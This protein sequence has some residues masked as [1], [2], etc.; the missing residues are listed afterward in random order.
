MRIEVGSKW[1]CTDEDLEQ[2][3]K[4]GK[5]LS[6]YDHPDLNGDGEIEI[7]HEDGTTAEMKVRRFML[8]YE[9]VGLK[10]PITESNPL[11][12]TLKFDIPIND[13][14]QVERFNKMYNTDTFKKTDDVIINMLDSIYSTVVDIMNAGGN[15]L[16]D[17]VKVKIE[18]EYDP[19]NK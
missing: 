12:K 6:V 5:V 9:K 7:E 3:N 10:K 11:K 16:G 13:D 15:Y 14:E 1:L 8:R 4:T 18:L 2:F 17:G 19:E